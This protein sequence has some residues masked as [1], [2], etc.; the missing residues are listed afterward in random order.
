MLYSIAAYF[1]SPINVV[2]LKERAGDFD[3]QAGLISL[4]T[5]INNKGL[6]LG[7][8]AERPYGGGIDSVLKKYHQSANI[9][10]ITARNVSGST[11]YMLFPR[12]LDYTLEYPEVAN[13]HANWIGK[14]GQLMTVPL[15]E[16]PNM[17]SAY[18]GCVKT[19]TGREVVR[20]MNR[21]LQKARRTQSY[22]EAI[23]LALDECSAQRTSE[24]MKK[25]F[26]D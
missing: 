9:K 11:I 2:F 25:K 12:R 23:T 17:Y 21:I 5:L 1:M 18:S 13:Y 8:I 3:T 20:K 7:I 14:K 6:K 10:S 19:Q 24:I 16:S 26:S 22:R 15:K 4:D